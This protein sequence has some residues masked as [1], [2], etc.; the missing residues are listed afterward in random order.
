MPHGPEKMSRVE[1]YAGGGRQSIVWLGVTVHLIPLEP[2]R[3]WI[4][5]NH[6]EYHVWNE[7]NDG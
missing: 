5:N 2:E 3:N 6:V 1:G 7:M 4:M